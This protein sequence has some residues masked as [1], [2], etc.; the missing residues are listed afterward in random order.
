MN[1]LNLRE[2]SLKDYPLNAYDKIRFG[3]TDKQGHVNNAV[4]STFLETGRVELLYSS[5]NPLTQF[6]G[7]FVIASLKLD[8]IEEI[9]WPGTV[10]IGTAV[11]KIGNSSIGMIQGLYQNEKIVATAETVI[12]QIDKESKRSKPLP[13]EIKDILINYMMKL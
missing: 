12:V 7:S 13:Q 9:T 1:Q 8:L 4:F 11:S 6:G 10:E 5:V 3:D 2:L